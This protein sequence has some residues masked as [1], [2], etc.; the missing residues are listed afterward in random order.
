MRVKMV[1]VLLIRMVKH[2]IWVY[3]IIEKGFKYVPVYA[4]HIYN[5]CALI[6]INI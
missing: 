1:A 6:A 3:G 4:S 5:I 2:R